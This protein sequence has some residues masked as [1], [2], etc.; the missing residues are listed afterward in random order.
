[1]SLHGPTHDAARVHIQHH[2]QVQKARPGRKWSE[3]PDVVDADRRLWPASARAWQRVRR[4]VSRRFAQLRAAPRQEF[5][6]HVHQRPQVALRV[7]AHGG[8]ELRGHQFGGASFPQRMAW[9]S[10]T[11]S[12]ARIP[13]AGF[14]DTVVRGL[15]SVENVGRI[16]QARQAL[17]S[18]RHE[19]SKVGRL[20][21][22]CWWHLTIR[23]RRKMSLRL[24]CGDADCRL[25]VV[26][27]RRYELVQNLALV[28]SRGYRKTASDRIRQLRSSCVRH[29]SF[30]DASPLVRASRWHAPSPTVEY[31]SHD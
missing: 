21:C 10:L 8:D 7:I 1:M 17:D 20:G 13:S 16:S 25:R 29:S 6:G 12:S 27:P 3:G 28:L 22:H 24:G 5:A 19:R 30:H 31:E 26:A 9:R 4:T 18:P 11:P 15:A 14:A 2:R 23:Q